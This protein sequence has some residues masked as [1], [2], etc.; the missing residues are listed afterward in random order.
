MPPGGSG[1]PPQATGGTQIMQ[2]PEMSK[3]EEMPPMV[4]SNPNMLAPNNG[5]NSFS[6]AGLDTTPQ[7]RPNAIAGNR[8]AQS[9]SPMGG[10]SM[11]PMSASGPSNPLAQQMM[12]NSI[13][14]QERMIQNRK[15]D[16]AMMNGVY[17]NNNKM[18][19]SLKEKSDR[20]RKELDKLNSDY[21]SLMSKI[22]SQN[23]E[24]NNEMNNIDNLSNQ[25]SNR[26]SEISS[27]IGSYSGYTG[28]TNYGS[29]TA[30]TNNYGGS[31]SNSYSN[32]AVNNYDTTN[33]NNY[34][35]N[36]YAYNNGSSYNYN[37]TYDNYQTNDYQNNNYG[38]GGSAGYS[39]YNY[40]D[41]DTTQAKTDTYQKQKSFGDNTKA[42]AGGGGGHSYAEMQARLFELDD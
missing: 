16:I 9:P 28:S 3:E 7:K 32:T 30:T 20:L 19:S 38:G 6:S 42:D 35:T 39:N 14:D 22:S 18:L 24:I 36:D 27:A 31:G 37:D 8:N 13:Q 41:Q 23:T 15:D 11:A 12:E 34:N 10:R 2:R 17:Q 26:A 5:N 29:K 1:I 25:I 40:Y 4:R 33:S 21:R